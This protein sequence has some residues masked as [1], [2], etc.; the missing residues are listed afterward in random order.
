[1]V[2]DSVEPLFPPQPT[3]IR[4][5]AERECQQNVLLL[6]SREGDSPGLRDLARR[7]ELERLGGG[8]HD[9]LALD[10]GD[11]R[12]AVGELGGD[13][14]VRV[15]RLLGLD[16][17]AARPA[18][19]SGVDGENRLELGLGSVRTGSV[20]GHDCFLWYKELLTSRDAKRL[21]M[22]YAVA[23]GVLRTSVAI[24][25]APELVRVHATV[26]EA[27]VWVDGGWTNEGQTRGFI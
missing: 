5:R 9:V 27:G 2:A 6:R 16:D 10:D 3:I 20:G 15:R 21:V 24:V 26:G 4:L 17:D 11:I 1:M 8:R 25:R 13:E 14:V 12:A 19:G 7:L 23:A 22:Y 18:R